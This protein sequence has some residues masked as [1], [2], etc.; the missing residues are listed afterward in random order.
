MDLEG[1][2]QQLKAGEIRPVYLFHGPEHFLVRRAVKAVIKGALE[3]GTEDFNLESFS[4]NDCDMVRFQ[5][6]VGTLPFM[7]ER[8]VVVLSEAHKLKDEDASA[9][10]AYLKNAS[11]TTCLVIT[12]EEVSKRRSMVNAAKKAGETVSFPRSK[13]RQLY[14]WVRRLAAEKG[15]KLGFDAVQLFV[16]AVGADLERTDQELEKLRLYVG[17]EGAVAS[18]DVEQVVTEVNIESVFKF[19]D[20]VADKDLERA[21]GILGRMIGGGERA[22]GI[23]GMIQW[24]FRRLLLARELFD[25]GASPDEIADAISVKYYRERFISQVEKFSINEL[26]EKIKLICETDLLLKAKSRLPDRIVLE[27]LVMGLCSATA[28]AAV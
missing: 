19:T 4:G 8:R 11:P 5:D 1:L 16:D 2:Y 14:A 12:A 9:L 26:T 24:Q 20:A 15:L 7:A 23:N 22:L 27:R 28:R 10:V 3:Q 25:R 13:G 21:L 18:E 6:A 17:K